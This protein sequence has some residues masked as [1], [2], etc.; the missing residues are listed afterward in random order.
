[1]QRLTQL[2]TLKVDPSKKLS[3]N[4][5]GKSY[6]GLANDTVATALYANGLRI[7][8]RSIKYHRPRGLYSLDGECGNCLME[9][10]GI[11]NEPA[12]RTPLKDN[13][14]VR[15]HN[16]VGSPEHDLMGFMDLM[17]WAMPAGFYY[18][19]FHRPYRLWPFFLRQ[20]R[21]TAG[22]GSVD[23][24]SSLEGRF[25]EQYL[26]ADVCVIGGGPAGILA[27]LPGR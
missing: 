17:G 23:P 7:F 15:P 26:H 4:Y 27:S 5:M 14:T 12:E 3:V 25:D 8:S 11:P 18:R 6:K 2:P 19:Y 24:L 9:I 21:K 20:I 22:I 10:A 13:M 1:M 16:V